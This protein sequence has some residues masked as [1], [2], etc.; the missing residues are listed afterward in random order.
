M[1]FG[2]VDGITED[3]RQK[4]EVWGLVPPIFPSLLACDLALIAVFYS[5]SQS[6]SLS[7]RF[8]WDREVIEGAGL[9]LWNWESPRQ[10][11]INQSPQCAPV[12]Q[13]V[14]HRCSN[15]YSLT[16]LI[17]SWQCPWASPDWKEPVA[18]LHHSCLG[19]LPA[20]TDS[21]SVP[22]PFVAPFSSTPLH[23]VP[24]SFQ[25]LTLAQRE[26]PIIHLYLAQSTPF[27]ISNIKT[28]GVLLSDS[29]K[30]SA[31]V[32]KWA[33]EQNLHPIFAASWLSGCGQVT[34]S[35]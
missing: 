9:W 29:W 3:Q 27:L 25:A 12:W 23:G 18:S 4:R 19:A 33:F 16:R 30:D 10:T 14:S 17:V 32:N 34:P 7:I 20:L 24:V 11:M 21:V 6:G 1:E 26:F 35:V 5:R 31:G 28:K 2:Q 22:A 15:Y 8:A 13:P